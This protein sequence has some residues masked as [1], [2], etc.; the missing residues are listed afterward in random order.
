MITRREA[1]KT[2]ATFALASTPLLGAEPAPAPAAPAAPSGPFKLPPLGY[3][4]DA[5]EPYIDAKTM[6]IHH[7]KHHATYVANLNKALADYPDLQTKSVEELLKNLD[8]V[9]EKIR[10]TVKNNAGGHYNHSLFWQCLKKGE[11]RGPEGKLR[12]AFGELYQSD[13]EGQKEFLTKALG[14]FGSG[15]VWIVLNKDKALKL[16]AT[17]N[18]DCPLSQ[19]EIPLFGLDLWEHAYYLKYQNRRKDYVEAFHNFINWDFIEE[20]YEKLVS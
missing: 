19:G 17:P 3:A 11:G 15:W 1:L 7:G 10:N 16:T 6:E 5:L 8:T 18:Q 4:F 12:E 13:E 20:R 14:V 2:A 9:P